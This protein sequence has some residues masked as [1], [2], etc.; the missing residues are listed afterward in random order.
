MIRS[1]VAILLSP[2][3][4]LAWATPDLN[5]AAEDVCLCLEEPYAQAQQAMELISAAQASGDTSALIAAQGEMMGV[6]GASAQ[7]FEALPAKYPEINQSQ[8]LQQQ[9][10]A[11]ADEKCPNPAAAMSANQ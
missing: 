8:E 3:C 5:A 7:C 6:I 11:I 1:I 2:I 10:M 4:G 9:V